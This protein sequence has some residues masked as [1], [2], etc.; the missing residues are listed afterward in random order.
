MGKCVTTAPQIL[1][2]F[3][4]LK[5]SL[6]NAAVVF[7]HTGKQE[8]H[9]V[10]RLRFT[11]RQDLYKWN[12]TLTTPVL[13]LLLDGQAGRNKCKTESLR[14]SRA[15]IRLLWDLKNGMCATLNCVPASIT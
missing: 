9:D 10:E 14:R 12:A 2:F 1:F 7:K 11:R 5:L 4:K 6:T 3:R 13:E 15:L 8:L